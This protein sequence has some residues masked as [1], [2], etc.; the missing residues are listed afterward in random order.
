M[1][2]KARRQKL[3]KSSPC[4]GIPR[5][6]MCVCVLGDRKGNAATSCRFADGIDFQELLDRNWRKEAFQ[7]DVT[8]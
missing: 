4:S 6:E 8:R 3:F 2:R 5:D 1:A 7:E